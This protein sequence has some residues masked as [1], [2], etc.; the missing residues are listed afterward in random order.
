MYRYLEKSIVAFLFMLFI[1][2]LSY[3]QTKDI[4]V[5]LSV[6][7]RAATINEIT[8]MRLDELLAR[9]MQETGFDMWIIVCNEDNLDPVFKT[10]IPYDTWCPIIQILSSPQSHDKPISER[11]LYNLPP[12]S[13]L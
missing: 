6:R 4:P 3:T 9:F 5:V 8:K 10:M 7:D 1:L 12:F 2:Q 11:I 13:P